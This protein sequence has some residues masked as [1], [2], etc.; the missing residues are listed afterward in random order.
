MSRVVERPVSGGIDSAVEKLSSDVRV[1]VILD[2]V[3]R[4]PRQSPRYQGPLV[5]EEAVELDDELVLVVGEV[6]ALEVGAEVVDPAEA[7]ALAAAEESGGFG[8]RAPAALAV[9]SDVS[10]E[11]VVF[12]FRPRPFVRV[13][14][15]TAR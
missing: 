8:E 6:A 2:L 11:P 14:F 3:V 13:S 1:P 7:A 12:L 4:S 10:D 15:L 5:A 9:G